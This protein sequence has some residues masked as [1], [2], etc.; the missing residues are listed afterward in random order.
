[1]T[2]QDEKIIAL[3]SCGK[4]GREEVAYIMDLRGV[5]R[6]NIAQQ[7]NVTEQFVGLVANGVKHSYSVATAISAAVDVPMNKLWPGQYNYQPKKTTRPL[8][9]G[10]EKRA[11]RAFG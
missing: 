4:T 11:M 9:G 5:T 1:M 3:L 8:I 2:E 7:E 10:N 6:R